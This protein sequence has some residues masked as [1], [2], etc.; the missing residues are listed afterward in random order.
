MTKTSIKTKQNMRYRLTNKIVQAK[1]IAAT[2]PVVGTPASS[3]ED[4]IAFCARVSSGRKYQDRG[5]DYEGLLR[6]CI[7]NKHWSIFEMA[8]ATVEITVP[9]D[10]SR[11]SNRHKSFNLQEFS[12]RYSDQFQFVVRDVRREDHNNRQ[13]S[14]DDFTEEQKKEFVRDC[15]DVIN[16]TN[17]KFK[18]WR[19]RGAAKECCRVFLPEGLTLS[20][21]YMKGSARSWLHYLEVREG[22]GTQL[23]HILL[24]REIRKVL[25]P[26]FPVILGLKPS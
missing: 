17:N 25:L 2:Q 14:V 7:R 5:K 1:L 12:Q 8:D 15:Q 18:K 20:N 19:E 4:L 6:Y 9:R 13:N 16:F 3:A 24:A 26:A 10:I 11:Q 21:V 22:N 23:E